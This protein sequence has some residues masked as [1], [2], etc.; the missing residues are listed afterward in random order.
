[1]LPQQDN[2]IAAAEQQYCR[3]RT[4]MLPQKTNE[5]DVAD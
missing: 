1:M 3:S 4:T 2:N 5:N